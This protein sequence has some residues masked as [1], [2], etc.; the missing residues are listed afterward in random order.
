MQEQGQ[1]KALQER[2]Q[3]AVEF[4]VAKVSKDVNVIAVILCG[5]LAYDAVWEKS[6]I[7]MTVIVRDQ[8]LATTAYCFVEDDITIN[9]SLLARS[10]FK[11]NLDCATGGSIPQAYLAKGRL[12]YTT[13]DSLFDYFAQF[14]RLGSQDIALTVMDKAGELIDIRRKCEK[15][16]TVKKDRLYAQFY[17]LKAAEVMAQMEVCS[18]GEPPTRESIQR[19]MELTPELLAPFY[20]D[21]LSHPYTE[22]E[23]LSA[24]TAIDV[25]LLGKLELIKRPVV[26]FMGDGEPKSV[27]LLARH[28]QQESHSIIGLLEYLAE[29]E[30]LIKV[31]QTIRLT[32]KSRPAIEELAFLYI[33]TP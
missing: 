2:Y 6:D 11:R 32:P 25:F 22:S 19:V 21:A 4:F 17:L 10:A 15:W 28:F 5:S 9:A 16:L 13:D 30:V 29:Q 26:D 31:A 7:D 23:L 14:K 12:V 33:P 27:T 3:A 18:I 8:P 24:I 1:Q 20:T